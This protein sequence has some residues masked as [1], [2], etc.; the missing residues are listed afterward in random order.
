MLL[1]LDNEIYFK[2]VFSDPTVFRCFVRDITGVDAEFGK[3]ETEKRFAPK[4]GYIDFKY[5]IFAETLDHRIIVE[6]QKVDYDYNF[7]RFLLYHNIA[8][9]ELQRS[10]KEYKIT[11]TVYTIVVITEPYR[12]KDRKG[13]LIKNDILI[14]KSNFFTF[15]DE[16]VDIFPHKLFCLNPNYI[17]AKTPQLVKDWLQLVSESI[18]HPDNYQVN[19]KNDGIKAVLRVIKEK[20]MTI[21]ERTLAKQAEAAK[22]KT[23]L[24][25]EEGE[26]KKALET[27]ANLKKEGI[28][29][30]IIAKC[31][32]LSVEEINNI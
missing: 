8:L 17:N 16:E 7:D 29:V 28:S 9:A 4:F 22:S 21:Q 27:A 23:Q 11:K 15:D 5:D 2:K 6:I 1:N 10:S 3:I 25:R 18:K 32:G 14:H 19:Q 24:I 20:R 26:R 12:V 31:T 13:A 30:N